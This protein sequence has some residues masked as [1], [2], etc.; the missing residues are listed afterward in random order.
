MMPVTPQNRKL[1]RSN[2]T[3]SSP[4]TDSPF[5][6][7]NK[8]LFSNRESRQLDKDTKTLPYCDKRPRPSSCLLSRANHSKLADNDE[9]S[10]TTCLSPRPRSSKF[11]EGSMNDRVSQRPPKPYLD[12]EKSPQDCQVHRK[13]KGNSSVEHIESRNSIIRLRKS[14]AA[15]INL[16]MW[17]LWQRDHDSRRDEESANRRLMNA[18]QQKA[19]KAYSEY[20]KTGQFTNS[21][22]QTYS[23]KKIDNESSLSSPPVKHD[24]GVDFLE[25]RFTSTKVGNLKTRKNS[26]PSEHNDVKRQGR[27]FID[28]PNIAHHDPHNQE[29]ILSLSEPVSNSNLPTKV[30]ADSRIRTPSLLNLRRTL[31]CNS[32][33]RTSVLSN[34]PARKIP[35]RKDLQHQ[36]KLVKRISN[37]E[38]KLELAK[39][40]LAVATGE[41]LEQKKSQD[42]VL[43]RTSSLDMR[44]PPCIGEPWTNSE[45]EDHQIEIEA[46]IKRECRRSVSYDVS[47]RKSTFS[48]DAVKNKSKPKSLVWKTKPLPNEPT[49][50]K[51]HLRANFDLDQ[52]YPM[53]SSYFSESEDEKHKRFKD[54]EFFQKISHMSRK[55]RD[56]VI[57]AKSRK[58]SS[59]QS[60][61]EASQRPMIN[62][63]TTKKPALSRPFSRE[64][65][66]E[67]SK[68]NSV[69]GKSPSQ[70]TADGDTCPESL[71]STA[72]RKNILTS[73]ESKNSPQRNRA[74]N[75]RPKKISSIPNMKS[76]SCCSSSPPISSQPSQNRLHKSDNYFYP[77]FVQEPASDEKNDLMILNYS[78][79]TTPQDYSNCVESNYPYSDALSH[80]PSVTDSAILRCWQTSDLVEDEEEMCSFSRPLKNNGIWT[81]LGN[82]EKSSVSVD[83]P[84]SLGNLFE[85]PEDVF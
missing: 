35:S 49:A 79:N 48:N 60:S 10:V 8:R 30:Q 57:V 53:V 52:T 20:K 15:T 37:L 26:R 51:S 55:S 66:C 1:S 7:G 78:N 32:C 23:S 18:R 44:Q 77:H 11:L 54:K 21:D 84:K 34:N 6:A 63:F 85:W 13:K 2:S 43:R 45:D 83:E 25:K 67:S 27:V 3:K 5:H 76:I 73:S 16:S 24:S 33:V 31:N 17:K 56:E 58:I 72:H 64:I 42:F 59:T 12:D 47:L 68:T 22:L 19:E 28:P 9:I 40:Q 70:I 80:H 71:K 81:K 38:V 41:L 74:I 75:R 69:T 14:I 65:I 82:S 46:Q 36:Q 39:H 29:E 4:E 50:S 61:K 62:Q